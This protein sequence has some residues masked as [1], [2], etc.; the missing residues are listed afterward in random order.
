[1]VDD[2]FTRRLSVI[3]VNVFYP[4]L[5][6][7]ALLSR[8]T[9]KTL[10]A[11]WALP[12]AVFLIH[13]AGWL[14]GAAVLRVLAFHGRRVSPGA[15][16]D[17]GM[18]PPMMRTFHFVCGV[19]NYS[20]L[21][22]MLA[23]PLWGDDA[24][25][26][27]AFGALGAEV[28]VWTLGLRVLSGRHDLGQLLSAP[29]IALFS[30]AFFLLARHFLPFNAAPVFIREAGGMLLSTFKTA[31]GATIPVSALICGARIGAL[32]LRGNLA[33]PA[34]IFTGLRLLLI[35]AVCVAF[36]SFLPLSPLV[37]GVLFLIA[38]QPAAM[39][40]VPMSEVYGGDPAFAAT[41]VFLTHL[42]CLAT[43][44]LWMWW[45]GVV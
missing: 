7:N 2:V 16:A 12:V 35:P 15:T 10:L 31:G 42:L 32:S 30:A 13:F 14:V 4:C 27:I 9:L 18:R 20:F 8:F 36:L 34:W 25:A 38:V 5:I 29:L 26:C 24:V 17:P 43:I 33:F 21:P 28:F 39:A 41:A 11:G 19:N 22:I 45:L 23:R 37:R 1:M 3:L 44:P 6:L 40:S